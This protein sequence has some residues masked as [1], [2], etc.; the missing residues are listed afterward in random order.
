MKAQALGWMICRVVG[1][2]FWVAS[3]VVFGQD[4]QPV[5]IIKPRDVCD[6]CDKLVDATFD[7]TGERL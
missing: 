1:F 7:L 3:P 5:I 2:A 6:C 4:N